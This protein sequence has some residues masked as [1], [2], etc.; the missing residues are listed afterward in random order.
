MAYKTSIEWTDRTWN[1]ITGCSWESRGCDNCYAARLAS[2]RMKSHPSREGLTDGKG[3]FNGQVRFNK[4][5][6]EQ[7]FRWKK[8]S[9]IFVC[10]HADLFH[11]A[12][13]DGWIMML[14]NVM[15]QCPSHTFQVLTKRPERMREF[16]D[17]WMDY[18]EEDPSPKLARGPE[19]VRATHKSGRGQLFAAY[20]DA[21][22]EQEGGK[23]PDGAAFPPYDWMEGMRYWPLWPENVWFGVSAEDQPSADRRVAELVKIRGVTRWVSLEPLLAPVDMSPWVFDRDRE[24]RRLVNGPACLNRDQAD[25]SVGRPLDWVVV[26]GESGPNARPMNPE[27]ARSL[28][29]RCADSKVPFFFKQHGGATSKSGGREL[30]GEEWSQMPFTIAGEMRSMGL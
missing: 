6:L 30:D 28:R 14:L 7:P 13:P 8:P 25:A 26:G 12:V 23:I 5:W 15:Y 24:I 4:Q 10:A 9:R 22:L 11:P 17:R 16:L 1:P 18:A 21:M 19:E 2:T 3:N 20:L 29:D 27:W